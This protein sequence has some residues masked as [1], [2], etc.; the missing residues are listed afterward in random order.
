MALRADLEAA[1]QAMFAA[2]WETR[3]GRV[4]PTYENLSL[5]NEGVFLEAAVLYAD[6]ADSTAMVDS[7]DPRFAA[8]V[9]KAFLRCSGRVI[10]GNKG[11][12][13]AYDGD[14]VMGVFIGPARRNQAVK[15]ALNIAYAVAEIIQPLWDSQYPEAGF[16]LRHKTGVDASSLLVAKTGVRGANDLVWVGR[17]ANY[18][19]KLAANDAPGSWITNEVYEHLL[20]AQL[21]LGPVSAP[22]GPELWTRTGQYIGEED[23]FHTTAMQTFS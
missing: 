13:T 2:R 20:P 22:A 5:N 10:T 8:E 15:A 11:V 18:A 4:V 17:A 14:R 6:M 12:I 7:L 3:E 16:H 23:V 21:Y 9:Y 19:A 1:V